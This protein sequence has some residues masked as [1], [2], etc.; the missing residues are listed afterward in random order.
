LLVERFVRLVEDLWQILVF[1]RRSQLVQLQPP[2]LRLPLWQ[3][4][5]L[6]VS[7]SSFRRG[8][9]LLPLEDIRDFE[10]SPYEVAVGSTFFHNTPPEPTFDQ[11]LDHGA[12]VA[13]RDVG[14]PLLRPVGNVIAFQV[15]IDVDI[16]TEHVLPQE[17]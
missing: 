10:L 3:L 16:M 12:I 15:Q 1:H 13:C 6:L 14:F 8:G 9:L 4:F 17:L 7:N 2:Y 11:A 5:I